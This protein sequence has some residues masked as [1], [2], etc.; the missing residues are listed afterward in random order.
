MSQ[1]DQ[2]LT[3]SSKIQKVWR[4]FPRGAADSV[5]GHCGILGEGGSNEKGLIPGPTNFHMPGVYPK[6]KKKKSLEITLIPT[7][8]QTKSYSMFTIP[9]DL[10]K[11]YLV[12]KHKME[13]RNSAHFSLHLFLYS[14]GKHYHGKVLSYL[15]LSTFI[16]LICFLHL[17]TQ[18]GYMECTLFCSPPIQQW[19]K[20]PLFFP[21]VTS[22]V[23][24]S[25]N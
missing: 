21:N 2:F 9:V 8:F 25:K 24:K 5:S 18:Q 10:S 19:E 13:K 1:R 20:T 16:A 3:C 23:K 12:I 14:L 11:V 6:K 15:F 7:P 17:F 4:R 22:L